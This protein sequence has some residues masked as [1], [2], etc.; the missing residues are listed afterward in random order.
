[1]WAWVWL[2]VCERERVIYVYTYT[3]T[4]A[5]W[6][7][8]K[9]GKNRPSKFVTTTE[10][11][12]HSFCRRWF[13]RPRRRRSHSCD[14]GLLICVTWLIH[15]CDMTH[16]DVWHE[17][18]ICVT[19]L[20]TPQTPPLP[21]LWQ[22]FMWHDSFIC[23]TWLI[24]TCDTNHLYVWHD[25]FKCVTQLIYVFKCPRHIYK[26]TCARV[27]IHICEYV[28]IYKHIFTH[29]TFAIKSPRKFGCSPRSWVA[30]LPGLAQ[31]SR[32]RS[33]SVT[34]PE[35]KRGVWRRGGSQKGGACMENTAVM[36]MSFTCVTW[37]IHV[38]VA[39]RSHAMRL[40][41][42]WDVP[43][44]YVWHDSFMRVAWLCYKCDVTDS[45]A[46]DTNDAEVSSDLFMCTKWHMYVRDMTYGVATI[47]RLLKIIGL[48][49]KRAL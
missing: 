32:T 28:Y 15:M 9:R 37:L 10:V 45:C 39:T 3:H 47:S 30:L 48:F 23:V 36:H 19:W 13:R 41:F 38:C 21:F 22:G 43:P 14:K 18:F 20:Q 35:K 5:T 27:Y 25:S 40:L 1:M 42:I 33:S 17:S 4:H 12:P 16:R 44:W 29:F 7:P 8:R 46:C 49:C 34:F 11:A 2:S 6:R 26:Y 31:M 24:A